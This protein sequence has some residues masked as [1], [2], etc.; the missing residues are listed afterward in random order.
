[1]NDFDVKWQRLTA[2]ARTAPAAADEA[3][4]FGFAT[5]VA[6][7]AAAVRGPAR[8][9]LFEQFALRAL[10][11]AG[12]LSVASVAY[13]FSALTAEAEDEFTLASDPLPELLDLS[14]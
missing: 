10:L 2:R 12:A 11:A 13:S 9:G 4:P 14:S 1:M 8:A 5:R 7:Q 3:A 6:A